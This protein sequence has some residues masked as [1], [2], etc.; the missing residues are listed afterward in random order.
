[1]FCTK[2]ILFDYLFLFI[3]LGHYKYNVATSRN[4]PEQKK[5]KR[6]LVQVVKPRRLVLLCGSSG[7]LLIE[8][9][10]ECS[11]KLSDQHRL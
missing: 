6:F 4:G 2:N 9:F 5:K 7:H 11:E 1:M 10:K 3:F 8:Q